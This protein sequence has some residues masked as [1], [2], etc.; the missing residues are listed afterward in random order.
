MCSAVRTLLVQARTLLT[1]L[2]PHACAQH[3]TRAA[4]IDSFRRTTPEFKARAAADP[5]VAD[6]PAAA[7]RFAA[8]FITELAA[9]EA[10]PPE[11][12]AAA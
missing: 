5:A 8:R 4:W 2:L 3:P 10:P 11:G 1:R 12:T 6:A 9:L 7:E